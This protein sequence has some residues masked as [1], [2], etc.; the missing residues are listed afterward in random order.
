MKAILQSEHFFYYLSIGYQLF[1]R[2]TTKPVLAPAPHIRKN[3]FTKVVFDAAMQW[4]LFL[5]IKAALSYSVVCIYQI[6]S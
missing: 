6:P 1:L 4:F 2:L 3:S 5:N